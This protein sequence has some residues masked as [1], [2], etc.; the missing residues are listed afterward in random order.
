MRYR[1]ICASRLSAIFASNSVRQF[2]ERVSVDLHPLKKGSIEKMAESQRSACQ[3]VR[4]M[5]T[6]E[7]DIA[8]IT[9][10]HVYGTK[11]QVRRPVMDFGN[12]SEYIADYPSAAHN[13]AS[14]ASRRNAR[15]HRDN[16]LTALDEDVEIAI[17]QS[18]GRERRV[19]SASSRRDCDERGQFDASM[20]IG[21]ARSPLAP[22]APAGGSRPA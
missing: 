5:S 7:F 8:F 1:T 21:L 11:D 12:W 2:A 9:P 10:V 13:P 16:L 14:S 20:E 18:R 15:I 19:G 22:P 3:G 6:T 17:R 4:A